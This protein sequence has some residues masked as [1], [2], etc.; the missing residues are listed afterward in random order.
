MFGWFRPTIAI[1]P[2]IKSWV[3]A[4][5]GWLVEQF[6]RDR[7]RDGPTILP[8]KEYFPERFDGSDDAARA[9]FDRTCRYMDLD[10][11]R[12]DLRIHDGAGRA[13]FNPSLARIEPNWAGLYD[14]QKD[15]PI[16]WVAASQL[17]DPESLVATFA[18]E[19]AHAHLIGGGRVS[20]EERDME[21]LTDLATVFFG[22][23]IFPANC[24]LRD[25]SYHVGVWETWRIATQG[26]LPVSVWSYA[27][28]VYAWLRHETNPAWTRFL[29]SSVRSPCRRAIA[30]LHKTGDAVI[31]PRGPGAEYASERL[32]RELGAAK[33]EEPELPEEDEQAAGVPDEETSPIRGILEVGLGRS[34]AAVRALSKAIE[35]DAGDDE[36][37][38]QR[39]MAYLEL[40]QTKEALADGEAA[41]RLAPDVS[42]N[43]FARGLARLQ[44]DQFAMAIADLNRFLVEEDIGTCDGT[45]PSKAYY[46]RG[47]ALAA[48]GRLRLALEDYTMAIQRWPNWPEPFLAR[49]AVYEQLG[50]AGKAAAD[51]R[52]A[53][54]KR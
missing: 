27:L 16:V 54:R 37:Y 48:Q 51:R 7:L 11:T 18:H 4:R 15:T 26:Y 41:V 35:I 31:E 19:L 42:E 17:N 10:P 52:E 13:R 30:Y 28:A 29:R 23:G 14:S 21:P 8:T 24:A 33:W 44:A 43:Y 39:C 50:K 20:G 1:E 34:D 22:L 38:Q 40:A 45:R 36:L 9:I 2:E 3:E 6:G 5:T 47:M 49:A 25:E 32:A 46:F 12:I 53:A